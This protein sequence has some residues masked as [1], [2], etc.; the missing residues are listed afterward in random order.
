VRPTAAT[1]K[2]SILLE[3]TKYKKQIIEGNRE[4]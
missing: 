3:N 4:K 1:E 2:E